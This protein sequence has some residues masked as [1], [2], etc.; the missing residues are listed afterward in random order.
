MLKVTSATKILK[1][2]HLKHRLKFFLFD[3]KVIFRSRDIQ[4]SVLNHPMF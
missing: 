3:R 4:V 2:F 1:V